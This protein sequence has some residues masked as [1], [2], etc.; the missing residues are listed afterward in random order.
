MTA[1]WITAC[2]CSSSRANQLLLG[3][4]VAPDAPVHMVNVT[5]NGGLLGEGCK[6]DTNST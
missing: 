1:R 3:V 6:G 2:F 5:D 4:D